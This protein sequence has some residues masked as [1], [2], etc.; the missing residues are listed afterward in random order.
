LFILKSRQLKK[1][2]LRIAQLLDENFNENYFLKIKLGTGS[3][4]ITKGHSVILRLH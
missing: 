1:T 3:D 2:M 4:L